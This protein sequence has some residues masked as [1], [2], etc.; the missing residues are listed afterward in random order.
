MKQ[1]LELV[2]RLI[3]GQSSFKY[4]MQALADSAGISTRYGDS[5]PVDVI[6][7]TKDYNNIN[8][9]DFISIILTWMI[10]SYTGH[11]DTKLVPVI[12]NLYNL[13]FDQMTV[14]ERLFYLLLKF[15]FDEMQFEEV[16]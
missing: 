13:H 10:R 7:L 1:I 2:A 6:E 14:A 9:Q 4:Q 15:R 8:Y 3:A 12:D 11:D 16:P 5:I